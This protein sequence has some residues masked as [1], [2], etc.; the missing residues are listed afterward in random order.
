LTAE[1]SRRRTGGD[2]PS[3]ERDEQLDRAFE[4][5]RPV[6]AV[7]AET[8]RPA[9]RVTVQHRLSSALEAFDAMGERETG[10][11]WAL[12]QSYVE[13][14]AVCV[15]AA[16]RMPPPTVKLQREQVAG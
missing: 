8:E 1:W 14:A 10:A 7:D 11:S 4:A 2:L 16:S 6:I 12:R 13:L 15:E 5:V 3:E 9:Q